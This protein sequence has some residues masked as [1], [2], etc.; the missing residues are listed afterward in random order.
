[1][2][3]QLIT[4]FLNAFPGC[5]LYFQQYWSLF[6]ALY[7]GVVCKLDYSPEKSGFWKVCTK[8]DVLL[9]C[10]SYRGSLH[11]LLRFSLICVLIYIFIWEAEKG[12]MYLVE[13]LS[14]IVEASCND[15]KCIVQFFRWA[16]DFLCGDR[17][18]LG[19]FDAI[20]TL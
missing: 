11:W 15:L 10:L 14:L 3:S 4:G 7:L 19:Y 16:T 1:L 6:Y 12:V 13:I 8:E 9:F 17:H 20:I 5:G 2:P 18:N